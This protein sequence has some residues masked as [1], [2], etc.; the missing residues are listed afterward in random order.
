MKIDAP[1]F[2]AN[3]ADSTILVDRYTPQFALKIYKMFCTGRPRSSWPKGRTIAAYHGARLMAIYLG[4][5]C[6]ACPTRRP[7]S[8]AAQ[9]ASR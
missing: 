5:T 3:L 7:K 6:L 9:I 1:V 4:V 8:T 2:Y